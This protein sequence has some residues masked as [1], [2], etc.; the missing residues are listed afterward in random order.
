[1]GS[2]LVYRTA[3]VRST[4]IVLAGLS[5]PLY[6]TVSLLHLTSATNALASAAEGVQKPLNDALPAEQ[7]F[8]DVLNDHTDDSNFGE[9]NAT[10]AE[11]WT[12]EAPAQ[13][14]QDLLDALTVMQDKYFS[15]WLAKWPTSIDWTAAVVQT[16]LTATLSTFSSHA[17]DIAQ[18]A[19]PQ[20]NDLAFLAHENTVNHFF[21]HSTSFY[22]GENAFSIRTQAYD[23][24]LWVVLEWLENIKFQ[25]LHTDLH[26][27][28]SSNQSASDAWYGTQF[29][30]A[31]AHRARIFWELA[32]AG[33]DRSLCGGGMV[34][35]PSLIPYK[36]AI[37]NELYISASIAMYL[38]FPGDPIDA[39]LLASQGNNKLY[40]DAAVEAYA[41]LKHSNMTRGTA[42]LYGDGFHISGWRGRSDPGS[43]KCDDLNH[44]VYTYNQ[45]VVLSGL[46]GLWLATGAQEYLQDGHDLVRAVQRATGWPTAS[47]TWAGLGRGGVLEEACDSHG[48]CSQDGQTFKGIFFHHLAE[49]CRPLRPQEKRFLDGQKVVNVDGEWDVIYR[50]HLEQCRGY[51]RWIEHNAKAALVTRDD[52]GR[53][54]AWW[55]LPFEYA[56]ESVGE[57]VVNSSVLVDGSIDYRNE[58]VEGDVK[59]A[60]GVPRDFND[61]GRGRTVETQSGGISVLRALLQW[62]TLDGIS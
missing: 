9:H 55:G 18:A 12:S 54:G 15:L 28:P 35:N 25:E 44:M 46:R 19:E 8:T 51:G 50:R 27:P 16:H 29:R 40:L 10:P 42:G 52:G 41:W 62:Q 23:D 49:F 48:S 61:R 56:F 53:F 5:W 7:S 37:T 26:Y 13:T 43:K 14:L 45:G 57:G 21:S 20:P 30:D 11:S 39:P 59:V 38:Y 24:M 3:M 4:W 31:A 33:W 17:L 6:L 22:Y 60:Q 34:W 32:A 1:M 58:E 2:S 36:N 47:K